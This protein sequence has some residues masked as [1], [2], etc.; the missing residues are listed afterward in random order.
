MDHSIMKS[1]VLWS[2][3]VPCI[4]ILDSCELCDCVHQKKARMTDISLKSHPALKDN[5]SESSFPRRGNTVG[6]AEGRL[7]SWLFLP[8]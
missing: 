7:L 4:L 3:V 8:F 2:V 6:N 5:V 1:L